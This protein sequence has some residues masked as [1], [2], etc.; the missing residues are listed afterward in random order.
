MLF[1]VQSSIIQNFIELYETMYINKIQ[2]STALHC[3]AQYFITH[4]II[5]LN[6]TLYR[7]TKCNSIYQQKQQT[8]MYINTQHQQNVI[9]HHKRK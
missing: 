7:K 9:T 3:T 1:S 6:N 8:I 5:A 4:H 2:Y